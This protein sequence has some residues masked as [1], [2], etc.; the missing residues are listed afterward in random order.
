MNQSKMDIRIQKDFS[1]PSHLA[2]PG[3]GGLKAEVSVYVAEGGL[4]AAGLGRG[5]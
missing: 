2:S 4:G 1:L 5:D 3:C